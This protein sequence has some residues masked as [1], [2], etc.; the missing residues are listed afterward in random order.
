ME[1]IDNRIVSIIFNGPP[2]CGKNYAV[3]YIEKVD[4]PTTPVNHIMFKERLFELTISIF[5][6]PD[7]IFFELYN[8]RETKE[9]P[10]SWL[11]NMS[12]REALIYVSEVIIKPL[13]GNDYFGRYAAT[14]LKVG[15]NLF[16]DGGFVDEIF[17]IYEESHKTYIVQIHRDGFD[18]S[19]DS[20]SYLKPEDLPDD[21]EFITVDN[22][23]HLEFFEYQLSNIMRSGL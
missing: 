1:N 5:D 17:P 15:F 6:I 7:Y 19:N 16:S 14:K 8:N 9:Q 12:P 11:N 13:F 21:V 4:R 23:S 20:R 2:N 22:N 18:F 3:D 10:T